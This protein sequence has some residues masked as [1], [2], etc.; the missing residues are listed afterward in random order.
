MP[1][2][3]NINLTK[4]IN[5]N[6]H[7]REGARTFCRKAQETSFETLKPDPSAEIKFSEDMNSYSK[8]THFPMGTS[9]FKINSEKQEQF[10]NVQKSAYNDS[11]KNKK[12]NEHMV[13]D[14]RYFI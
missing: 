11:D 4:S 8:I 5:F 13:K 10:S 3:K 6:P 7:S 14:D 12:W 9:D 1:V 2:Y